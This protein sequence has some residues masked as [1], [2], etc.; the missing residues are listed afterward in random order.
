MRTR[1]GSEVT[2]QRKRPSVSILSVI[3]ELVST[4][5]KW[6]VFLYTQHAAEAHQPAELWSRI[7]LPTFSSRSY[8]C[9]EPV[10]LYSCICSHIVTG[11]KEHHDSHQSL[12]S[13]L[14]LFFSPSLHTALK[15]PA[16][17]HEQRRSL[18][19]A[20]VSVFSSFLLSECVCMG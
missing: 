20:R 9:F 2:R 4:A 15:S 6:A 17:F 12:S 16:A 13:R 10:F 3:T 8:F 1:R 11:W 18:E 19:R 5:E 14:S 7:T